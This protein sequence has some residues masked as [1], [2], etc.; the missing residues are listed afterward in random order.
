V[1]VLLEVRDGALG[2]VD[3]QVGEVR[4]AQPLE[5]GVEVGEVAALQQRALGVH[6]PEGVHPE[7]WWISLP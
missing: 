7:A 4:A 1:P 6:Q 5:L 3:R 2:R